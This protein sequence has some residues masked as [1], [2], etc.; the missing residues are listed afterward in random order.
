MKLSLI[1]VDIL[2]T[3]HMAVSKPWQSEGATFCRP[4]GTTLCSVRLW[5][6]VPF[7][8][9]LLWRLELILW[10]TLTNFSILSWL[11]RAPKCHFSVWQNANLLPWRLI[12]R[13]IISVWCVLIQQ[14]QLASSPNWDGCPFFKQL[15]SKWQS[16]QSFFFFHHDGNLKQQP[17]KILKWNLHLHDLRGNSKA[18]AHHWFFYLTPSASWYTTAQAFFCLLLEYWAFLF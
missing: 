15:V 16:Y 14:L 7:L 17:W 8:C 1:L 6:T 2:S 10:P 4:V 18:A 9:Q 3:A 11:G 13:E 12:K 5:S